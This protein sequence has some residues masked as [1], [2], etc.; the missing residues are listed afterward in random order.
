MADTMTTAIDSPGLIV[1]GRYLMPTW[2]R[3]DVVRD[4]AVA[5]AGDTIVATGSRRDLR[6]RYPLAREIHEAHGLIM[7][8]LINTH[9]HAPM[10]CFRGFADDLPLM[11]WL[12]KHIFPIEAQL[13]SKIVHDSTLLSIVEMIKSGTTSFCDMYLFAKDVARAAEKS[14]IRCWV[15]EVLYDFPS[16]CYGPLDSGIDYVKE[17]FSDYENHPLISV[18]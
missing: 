9:T 14:G 18:T 11:T 6:A 10:A 12:E 2:R 13:N 3:E 5:I 17:M 8:G 7:P 1:S 16:P 15:G 4:G